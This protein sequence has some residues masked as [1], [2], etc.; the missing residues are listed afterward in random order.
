MTDA[1]DARRLRS[2]V[3]RRERERDWRALEA[4]LDE[5]DRGGVGALSTDRLYRLTALYRSALSSLSVARAISLDRNVVA[6]L[7][8]LC[9]RAYLVVY[10]GGRGYVET[11][12]DFALRRFPAL[13]RRLRGAVASSLALLLLGTA[14]GLAITSREPDLF[15]ALVPEALAGERTPAA[16][17]EELAA[18]LGAN[19]DVDALTLFASVLF[20]HNARV[21]M[22]AFAL[23]VLGALPAA[24]IVLYNGLLLGA[25]VAIHVPHGLTLE[26]WAWLLPHGVTELLAVALC[27]GAGLHTGLGLLVPGRYGRLVELARRG[28]EGA[29]VVL[30]AIVMLFFAA[31]LEG[32]FRQ[33]VTDVGARLAMAATTAALWALYFGVAGRERSP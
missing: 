30:G 32:F 9:A 24:L 12:R 11:L 10:G 23:G 31:L 16:S 29:L 5:V 27:A 13:V 1:G 14:C 28:R 8:S 15:F 18:A 21:G 19:D 3:F 17:R 22:S 20:S 26:V 4:L 2:F 33:L 7:E 25:F 6:Y